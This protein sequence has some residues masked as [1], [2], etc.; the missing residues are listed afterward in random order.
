[1]KKTLIALAVAASAVVS[2][3]AMAWTAGGNG[4]N[5]EL[6]GTLTPL[7]KYV[8]WE[9]SVGT[10]VN[11]LDA[12]ILKGDTGVS[13]THATAIP[14]LGIRNVANGFKGQPLI[15]PQIDYKGAVDSTQFMA[16]KKGQVYLDATV[17]D[18]KGS[19]I[20]TLKTILRVAAQANN[21][22]D[23]N[24]MLYASSASSGFFGGLPQSAEGVFDSPDAYSFARTLFPGIAENWSDNGTKFSVGNVGEFDFS[25]ADNTY[26]AYYAS[27]IPQDANLSITLDQ[28]AA[29]DAIK[30]H[31]SLPI[32]VSYN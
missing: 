4:G 24:V 14:V 9:V 17:N 28:P 3:S 16:D 10:A 19:K 31:V 29:S 7:D 27:G 18:D 15:D 26:H 13:I 20:G 1:M 5:L 22:V 11:N 12:Q 25:S 23:S 2:G 8:P 6:G 30:W 21:G 32:T